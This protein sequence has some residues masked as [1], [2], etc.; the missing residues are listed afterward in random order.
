MGLLLR[1]Y[2][3]LDSIWAR[4]LTVYVGNKVWWKPVWLLSHALPFS[5]SDLCHRGLWATSLR[6]HVSWGVLVG[7]LKAA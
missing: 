7:D 5:S 2:L 1:K 3:F 6:I 4:T